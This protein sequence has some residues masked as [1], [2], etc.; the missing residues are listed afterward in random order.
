MTP[1]RVW[2]VGPA[3]LAAA[4]P[5]LSILAA[6]RGLRGAIV[7]AVSA[8]LPFVALAV[9]AATARWARLGYELA[10]GVGLVMTMAGWG[11][12]AA[13]ALG[14]GAETVMAGGMGA[15]LLRA[16]PV[17]VLS[18]TVTVLAVRQAFG[19]PRH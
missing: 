2:R 11:M 13:G 6:G 7:P 1:S 14:G 15:L 19:M 3:V 4:V 16:L 18:V 9:L 5:V 12:A 8:A 10:A 17:A